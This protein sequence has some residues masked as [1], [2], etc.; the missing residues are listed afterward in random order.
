MFAASIVVDDEVGESIPSTPDVVQ[1][2]LSEN[3]LQHAV[4]YVRPA[5]IVVGSGE[6]ACQCA[7]FVQKCFRR[8]CRVAVHGFHPA[9]GPGDIEFV[10]FGQDSVTY[11]DAS[12]GGPTATTSHTTARPGSSSTG[13]GNDRAFLV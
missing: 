8:A 10:D 11:S 3:L 1:L 12:Y 5:G 4:G 2:E 9:L 13:K 7:A 6:R